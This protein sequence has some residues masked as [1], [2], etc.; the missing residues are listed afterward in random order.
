MKNLTIGQAGRGALNAGRRVSVNHI[1]TCP[2][3]LSSNQSKDLTQECR[4]SCAT[5]GKPPHPEGAKAKWLAAKKTKHN[6][7]SQT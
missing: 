2:Y 3:C 4:D 5:A 1:F 6:E 7:S